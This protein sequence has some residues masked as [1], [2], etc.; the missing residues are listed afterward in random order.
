M[1]SSH[2]DKN[3]FMIFS[4][5]FVFGLVWA[6]VGDEWAKVAFATLSFALFIYSGI[7]M[8]LNA[9]HSKKAH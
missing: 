5:M 9:L 3:W 2:K 8:E 6:I 4:V 7:K 1:K